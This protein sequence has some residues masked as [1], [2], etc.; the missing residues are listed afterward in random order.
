MFQSWWMF[1]RL[2]VA[3]DAQ[4][5][6]FVQEVKTKLCAYT[7]KQLKRNESLRASTACDAADIISRIS[8]FIGLPADMPD[9]PSPTTPLTM[10]SDSTAEQSE[11]IFSH[12]AAFMGTS[13]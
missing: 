8:E 4:L 10:V 13:R 11:V 3:Q 9:A 1:F 5:D 2:N 7:A 6:A 12:M